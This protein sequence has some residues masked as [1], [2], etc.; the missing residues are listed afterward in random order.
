MRGQGGEDWMQKDHLGGFSCNPA[1][2]AKSLSKAVTYRSGGE[3]TRSRDV[4]KFTST[5]LVKVS[6]C[7][8]SQVHPL[9]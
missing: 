6:G 2:S 9:S 8:H 1:G 4:R 7:L 3:E 5:S